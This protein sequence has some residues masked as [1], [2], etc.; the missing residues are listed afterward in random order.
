M[1]ITCSNIKRSTHTA[2]KSPNTFTTQH[3]RKSIFI[4]ERFHQK[5]PIVSI[6]FN[7]KILAYYFMLYKKKNTEMSKCVFNFQ[8]AVSRACW[9]SARASGTASGLHGLRIHCY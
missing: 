6:L 8:I 1:V 4:T 9:L 7:L 2:E 5:S 3:I